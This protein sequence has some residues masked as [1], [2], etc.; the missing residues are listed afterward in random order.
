MRLRFHSIPLSRV[1]RAAVCLLAA[2]IA[3]A[4][5]GSRAD[6]APPDP[7]TQV[8]GRLEAAVLREDAPAVQAV[9]LD[10]L[11]RLATAPA[12]R[13]PAI[14]YTVA[15]AAWRL[16]FGRSVDP[17]EQALLVDDA[18]TQLRTVLDVQPRHAEAL[19]LLSGVY[20]A[21]ISKAPDLGMTLGP[22]SGQLL[23]RALALEPDNP[24][25][26][27][28]RGQSLFHT[29]PE[30]GGSVREAET[31]LR[32]ATEAFARVGADAPW[33]H[34]GRFDAHA[35]L[36]QALAARQDKAGARAEYEKALALAPESG[37]VKY[38]LLPAVKLDAR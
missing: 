9:R 19:G 13:A 8:V 1:P 16:A 6:Q 14:R 34:W 30:Y 17:R 28:L 5:V 18:V 24:R 4:P 37:W 2:A 10:L 31:V 22:E 25:L 26:L 12:D 20:G 33:P 32:R 38:V 35:W 11:R 15:Y 36:G 23:S 21:K 3:A 29:P 7:F 27:L